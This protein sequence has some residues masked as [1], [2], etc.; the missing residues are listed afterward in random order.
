MKTIVILSFIFETGV[1][2]VN[3]VCYLYAE[4]DQGQRSRL[5]LL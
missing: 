2:T 3:K 5:S 4:I 1:R